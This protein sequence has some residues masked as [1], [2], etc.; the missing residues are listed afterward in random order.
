VLGRRLLVSTVLE[1]NPMWN[2]DT[3]TQPPAGVSA[4]HA[5]TRPLE[6]LTFILATITLVVTWRRFWRRHLFLVAVVGAGLAP[7]L[8]LHFESRYGLVNSFAYMVLAGVGIDAVLARI[9]RGADRAPPAPTPA[10]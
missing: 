3:D 9:R 8:V 6:P 2:G 4:S 5:L 10:G 1:V 7:Y